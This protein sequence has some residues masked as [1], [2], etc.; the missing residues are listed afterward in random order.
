M[1][2][3]RSTAR[4]HR[5]TTQYHRSRFESSIHL[6][7]RLTLYRFRISTPRVRPVT[8]TEVQYINGV[9]LTGSGQVDP[10][11]LFSAST[12]LLSFSVFVRSEEIMFARSLF[13]ASVL[14]SA[15]ALYTARDDSVPDQEIL[16][17]CPGGPGSSVLGGADR[18]TLVSSFSSTSAHHYLTFN[19]EPRSTS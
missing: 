11:L 14:G 12:T 8:D 13:I 19:V 3:R 2:R 1:D 18:C 15:F 9:P 6:S 4:D 7:R 10:T 16:A 5:R 17:S